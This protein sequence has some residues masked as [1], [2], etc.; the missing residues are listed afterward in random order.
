MQTKICKKCNI[1]KDVTEF[2]MQKQRN[3]TYRYCSWC[4]KCDKEYTNAW[5]RKHQTQIYEKRKEY[6]EQYNKKYW[7]KNSKE[8]MKKRNPY[9]NQKRKEDYIFKIKEQIRNLV[10]ISL[11]NKNHR[12]NT[13]TSKILGCDLDFFIEYI[14]GTYK[15]IYGYEWDKNESVHIDHIIPLATAKTEEEVIKL[16]HYTNLQL[17]K[18]EDNLKKGS[19][20]DYKI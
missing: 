7:K 16:C 4:K 18:A 11:K 3:G 19:K 6:I 14:L 2:R 9:F 15:A 5:K 8:I 10:N 12:K 13:K 20:T 17:L 1:E